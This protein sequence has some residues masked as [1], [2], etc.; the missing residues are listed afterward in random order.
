MIGP[1]LA[2]GLNL[3]LEGEII[4]RPYINLTLKVMKDFGAKA[5]WTSD[6]TLLRGK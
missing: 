5:E 3:E 4:S 6:H 1:M 2:H